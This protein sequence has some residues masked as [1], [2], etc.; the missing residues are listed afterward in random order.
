MDRQQSRSDRRIRQF[1]TILRT[2]MPRAATSQRASP[3]EGVAD[4]VL[5][6]QE[7]RHSA[8][9]MRVNHTSEVCV[10]ALYQGHCATAKLPQVHN[11][12]EQSAR[13]GMDH[14][15][16]CS[17]RLEELQ[18]RTSSLNPLFYAA[19]FG[20]GAATGAVSDRISLGF[21]AAT[22]EQM[23]KHL[24][25]QQQ[26]LPSEDHRSRTILR[27][28]AVDDSHHARLALETGGVSFPAPV[29]WGMRLVSNVVTKGVYYS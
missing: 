26:S 16:W 7:R 19:S 11:Q 5:D 17:E 24:E 3:A 8:S 13:E 2:L 25:T 18:S 23:V 20:I 1:D 22:E 9:I 10:Q 6:E 12:M 14:L 27:Q 21:V 15:A 28:M 29:K 4:G